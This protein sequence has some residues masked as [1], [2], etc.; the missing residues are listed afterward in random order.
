MPIALA[1]KSF[2][3]RG[4][5]G[6]VVGQQ[7]LVLLTQT[8]QCRRQFEQIG[9]SLLDV[10]RHHLL[11]KLQ[12]RM[13]QRFANLGFEIRHSFG[14]NFGAGRDLHLGNSSLGDVFDRSQ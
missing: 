1:H 14:T 9:F 2:L 12:L 13:L 3:S 4:S 5:L 6:L 8:G 11:E 10:F 7:E